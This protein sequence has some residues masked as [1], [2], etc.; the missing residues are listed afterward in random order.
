MTASNPP[1]AHLRGG[2]T[3]RY[4][5]HFR[6]FCRFSLQKRDVYE[7]YRGFKQDL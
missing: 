4:E 7:F 3:F 1:E 5:D 2:E 6:S